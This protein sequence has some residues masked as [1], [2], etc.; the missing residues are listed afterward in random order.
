MDILLRTTRQNDVPLLELWRPD[1]PER[2]PL[3][4]LQHGY[5]GRKEFILPQAYLLAVSGFFVVAP[6]ACRHGDRS[7]GKTPALFQSVRETA[8]G[9]NDLLQAYRDDM[10][11]D[12][13]RAGFVGYSMGGLV[14]FYYLAQAQVLF[15]AVC[16]VIAT[17]DFAA[18][19]DAPQTRLMFEQAGLG[20]EQ[21][22]EA[23]RAEARRDNPAARPIR[24]LPLLIQAGEADPLIP[25]DSIRRFEEKMKPQYQN[26]ENLSVLIY[27]GQGHADTIEMNQQIVAFLRRHLQGEG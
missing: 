20:S 24:P 22:F 12:C 15:K 19:A 1:L 25:A 10:R 2:R 11:A 27:P 17:P 26:P 3:V 9:L 21:A 13:V 23:Q 6:D 18:V 14:G 5:L 8:L 7:D 4:I 16:P